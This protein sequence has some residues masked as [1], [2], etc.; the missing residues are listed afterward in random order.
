MKLVFSLPCSD[1]KAN[2]CSFY[3]IKIIQ[4][5]IERKGKKKLSKTLLPE[6]TTV[7]IL[8]NMILGCSFFIHVYVCMCV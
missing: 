3:E 6:M 5:Y 7:N 2:I 4:K 1:Y 8:V